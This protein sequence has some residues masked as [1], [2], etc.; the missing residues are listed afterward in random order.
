[1]KDNFSKQA[2]LYAKYRP[3][4]PREIYE[5]ILSQFTERSCAW[6]C[7]TG[8]GQVAKILAAHFEEVKATD[9]SEEQLANA[10]QAKNIH[11]SVAEAERTTFPDNHFDLVTVGQALHWFDF[12]EFFKEVKRV[13][14]PNSVLAVWG[15]SNMLI[16]E[17]MDKLYFDFYQNITGPYWDEERKY[18]DDR[19]ESI[20]F[21]FELV[22]SET[23][24]MIKKWDI[25]T[26]EGFFNT[27]SA[28]QHFIIKEGYNPG[29]S[30]LEKR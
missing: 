22:Q 7:A 24:E 5:H 17:E 11:Y 30:L 21:P 10:E 15:Y 18:I 2:D 20:D 29:K 14:K 3:E 4:Y 1:M 6:D 8:N 9:I 16:G 13:L 25:E 27:W 28:V 26:L 19:Y 12:D 23:F